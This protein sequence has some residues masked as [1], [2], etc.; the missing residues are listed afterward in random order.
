MRSARILLATAAASAAL[1]FATPGAA[2][3]VP[4][5]HDEGGD[6]SSYS[7]EHNSDSGRDHD[8]DYSKGYDKDSNH[9]GPRGGMRTGG[10]ALAAVRGDDWSSDHED[11]KY[12]SESYKDKG[13]KGD[14][15]EWGGDD[16]DKPRGGMHT[17]GGALASPGV[18]AGGL[19]T[20]AVGATGVYALRRK[21]AGAPTS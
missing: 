5:G 1:A 4:A 8:K 9:D 13:D 7:K 12:D 17:G 6:D 16:H 21:K 10:G 20:L 2:F 14:K 11:K 18:T 15:G 3:A 19:A